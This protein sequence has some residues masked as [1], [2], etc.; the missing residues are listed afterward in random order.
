M[1]GS[2][3]YSSSSRTWLCG[4]LCCSISL[5]AFRKTRKKTHSI[6]TFCPRLCFA[7]VPQIMAKGQ[8]RCSKPSSTRGQAVQGDRW[9]GWPRFKPP[10]TQSGRTIFELLC[11]IL[12]DS[13]AE[14]LDSTSASAQHDRRAV[15]GLLSTRLG[16][17]SHEIE[18]LP[19]D[20]HQF[21][22]VEP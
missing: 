21:V 14:M 1:E 10:F 7:D 12:V 15:V 13:I 6:P 9:I 18:L 2:K 17:N 22:D 8:Y 16:V 3:A 5:L 19:H 11:N 4:Q 20:F